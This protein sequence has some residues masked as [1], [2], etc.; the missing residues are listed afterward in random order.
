[1]CIECGQDKCN[2]GCPNAPDPTV[3]KTCAVCNS[4]IYDY[5]TYYLD[6]G[7]V[8]CDDCRFTYCERYSIADAFQCQKCKEKYYTAT[9]EAYYFHGLIL[10]EKCFDDE[11]RFNCEVN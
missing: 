11:F 10:C 4:N 7:N 1:M 3:L 2:G 6:K 9:D 5:S 8:V